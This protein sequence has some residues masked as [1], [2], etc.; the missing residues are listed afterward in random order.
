LKEIATRVVRDQESKNLPSK[1]KSPAFKTQ[2][3]IDGGGEVV[4]YAAPDGEVRLDV[5]LERESVWLTLD[6]IA[7]LFRRDKSVISRHLRNIFASKE[8]L[9]KATVAKNATVQKE[10]T[11][12]VV[13]EIEYF[14]LDAILS[15]GYRVNSKRGTQF[16]IWA[17]RTLKDHLLRGY[18]LNEKRL[19]EKGLGEI[20]Q[21]VG[22]LT[23]TLTQ[24][25]L[26]TDQ[27][28]AVLE[29]VQQYTRA[30]R[31]LL[32]YDEG[33]LP[34]KPGHPVTPAAGLSPEDATTI[35]ARLRET[36]AARGEA[37]D[38]F[39]AE[40]SDQLAGILGAVEQTFDGLPLYPTVQARAAHLLYF[41]IKDHPFTD[42]NKRIGTLLF[43]EYLRRN[44]LL[45]RPDGSPRFAD[46][47]MV[48]LA[49]LVA[50]SEPVQKDLMIRLILNLL[51]D[52]SA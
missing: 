37:S 15:V 24:H 11:R 20:E 14:N 12:E 52:G 3:S 29:V 1:E 47:A 27:G 13:R 40:R 32:E 10:G 2:S 46:N 7:K 30:W 48:A 4:L 23:R 22:L 17:T 36:L 31:L 39:G 28:R 8:L 38:L 19:R 45:A 34:E 43:L 26:V 44:R 41:V 51:E 6:Q 33:R 9:R 16:R 49:L 5:R 25:A 42:G 50:E 21:A 35:I 18:T